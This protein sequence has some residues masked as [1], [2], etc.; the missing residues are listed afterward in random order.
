MHKTSKTP[1]KTTMKDIAREANLSV[2]AVSMALSG[3]SQISSSTRQR[4]R[5]ISEQMD[6]RPPR[7]RQRV[8]A[9]IKTSTKP[10][11][12]KSSAAAGRRV[13]LVNIGSV[14]ESPN[15]SRWL[16]ALTEAVTSQQMRLEL[17]HLG[18]TQS[19]EDCQLVLQRLAESVDGVVLMGCVKQATINAA[20]QLGLPFVIA[21]GVDVAAERSNTP[22]HLVATDELGMGQGA[23]RLLIEQGHRRIGF[24]C[25]PYPQGGW[26]DHWM[27]GY[28]MALIQAGLP[29]DSDI[30][31]VLGDCPREYVGAHAAKYMSSLANPPTAYVVPTV[32][33]AATFLREMARKGTPLDHKQIVMGGH[34]EEISAYGV[35]QFPLISEDFLGVSIRTA[36][37]LNELMNGA[38]LPPAQ[39]IM[40]YHVHNPPAS[41]K[42]LQGSSQ[43]ISDRLSAAIPAI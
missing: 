11:S 25:A 8:N 27:T 34:L 43:T 42:E 24:F 40:P 3:Y 15:L 41:H 1:K 9:N 16:K 7:Q 18:T 28:R 20:S 23:T 12:D 31:I 38:A 22:V 19:P 21:G 36:A 37:L 6:Y 13:G 10:V 33:G 29:D 2:T 5:V 26:N 17:D 30:R 32:R 39:I 4:V 35:N 14:P